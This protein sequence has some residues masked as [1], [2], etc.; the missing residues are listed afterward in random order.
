MVCVIA[1]AKSLC[2]MTAITVIARLPVRVQPLWAVAT[3]ALSAFDAHSS[4]TPPRPRPRPRVPQACSGSGYSQC[5]NPPNQSPMCA[6]MQRNRC[7]KASMY[8]GTFDVISTFNFTIWPSNITSPQGGQ[9]AFKY[10]TTGW[11]ANCYSA[12]C[13]LK[14]AWNGMPA[15]CYW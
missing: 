6:A 15:T 12:A 8:G 11:A 9:P 3:Y 1:G 7:G 10:C 14:R 2:M 13:M 5:A 4:T